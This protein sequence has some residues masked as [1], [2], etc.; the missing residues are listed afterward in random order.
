MIVILFFIESVNYID[1]RGNKNY[2]DISVIPYIDFK[3]LKYNHM[4]NK[5]QKERDKLYFENKYNYDDHS[6]NEYCETEIG[7]KF[8]NYKM[9]LNFDTNSKYLGI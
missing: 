8:N 9:R 2:K 5:Y 6:G 7:V 1:L 3:I 4:Y